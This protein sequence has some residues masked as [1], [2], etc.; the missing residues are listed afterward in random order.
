MQRNQ[1]GSSRLLKGLLALLIGTAGLTMFLVGRSSP[2]PSRHAGAASDDQTA[3]DEDRAAGA[4]A[5]QADGVGKHLPTYDS[6]ALERQRAERQRHAR[7]ILDSLRLKLLN[8]APVAGNVGIEAAG[9]A[10]V[11]Y[12][13]GSLATLRTISPETINEL[14]DA[15]ADRA[16]DHVQTDIEEMFTAH[17]VL[18]DR[19]LGAPRTFDC[20]LRDRKK[21][22]VVL[23]TALDAW[24]VAGRPQ[25]PSIADI[26]SAASD[27]RTVRRLTDDNPLRQARFAAAQNP[28]AAQTVASASPPNPPDIQHIRAQP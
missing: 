3:A 10:M 27:P 9:N 7:S 24:K 23:W 1:P 13:Q 8:L 16:C 25:V 6:F 21:E 17:M 15:L 14:R 4:P 18:A 2:A 28:P 22:D 20:M 12:I 19:D 11:P 5:A 26:T